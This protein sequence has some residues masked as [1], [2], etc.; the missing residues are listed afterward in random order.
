MVNKNQNQINRLWPI[1][2]N[3][4]LRCSKFGA[5]FLALI[6]AGSAYGIGYPEVVIKNDTDFDMEGHVHF[7]ACST[8]KFKVKRHKKSKPIS[9]G[10]CLVTKITAMGD[11]E[12]EAKKD[13]TFWA[14]Y[15][16]IGKN[17]AKDAFDTD[18]MQAEGEKLEHI[19]NYDKYF[20]DPDDY[21]SSGTSFSQFVIHKSSGHPMRIYS[22]SELGRQ[23]AGASCSAFAPC[24]RGLQCEWDFV[25]R[26]P[27]R[28]GESCGPSRKCG[29]NLKCQPAI[30]KCYPGDFDYKNDSVCKSF[31][32]DG[33][34]KNAKNHKYPKTIS[35]GLGTSIATGMSKTKET[36]A[37]YGESGEYGCY[38][39]TCTG[40]E[41]DIAGSVFGTFGEFHNWEDFEGESHGVSVHVS[42]PGYELGAGESIILNANGNPIGTVRTFS[43]GLGFVP[44]GATYDNC[45]TE[46][47]QVKF[48]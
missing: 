11:R 17:V 47:N 14:Q 24:G 36:G 20:A 46:L 30:Q 44:G 9:R 10:L 1:T 12:A 15:T 23:K 39:T 28:I 35:F 32:D 6:A 41:I 13:K 40:A 21:H 25:C 48:K 45:V 43:A 22:Q 27:S 3:N 4:L 37:V 33:I 5:F 42:V 2:M 31:Y 18:K 29:G 38:R 7:A 16:K 34:S 8:E 26:V 19:K